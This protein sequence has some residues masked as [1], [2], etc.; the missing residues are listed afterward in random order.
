MNMKIKNGFTLIEVLVV[1]TIIGILMGLS[2]FGFIGVRESARDAKRKTQIQ[3]IRGAL[4]LYKLACNE[5]P[6]VLPDSGQQLTSAVFIS[7]V[8][9]DPLTAGGYSYSSDGV[10]YELCAQLENSGSDTCAACATCNFKT[11]NP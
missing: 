9:A 11:K 5:Y 10:T 3:E 1:L 7:Q 4:E 6:L 8:P 2:V